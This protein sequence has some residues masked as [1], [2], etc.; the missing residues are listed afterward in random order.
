[1]FFT[2]DTHFGH[3]N[4]IKYCNR[5]FRNVFEM[6]DVLIDNWNSK[7][8]VN[9]IVYHLGDFCMGNEKKYLEALHG[10]I[11]FIEGSHDKWMNSRHPKLIELEVPA[12]YR[13]VEYPTYPRM[14]T[15]C[16]YSMRSWGLCGSSSG[17]D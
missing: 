14:L 11:I 12:I 15:L 3:A 7:V 10:K 1:M 9:D 4:I 13:D 6:D 17:S 5:P 2:A 16:H 8:G